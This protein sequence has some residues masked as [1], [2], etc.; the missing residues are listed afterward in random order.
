MNSIPEPFEAAAHEDKPLA[1]FVPMGRVGFVV[2]CT[3]L[4][5]HEERSVL[6][7]RIR[8]EHLNPLGIA[9]GGFL[10]TLADTAFGRALRLAAAT[11]LPPAT[12]NLSMDYLS[13]ANLGSWVEAHVQIH[14]VGRSLSHASLDLRD[15]ERLVARAKATFIGNSQ[16]LHGKNRNA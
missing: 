2:H 14:R 11:D 5:V 4:Y 3:G 1:G 8:P 7:A 9:H 6:A 12:I 10:A 15:G 13:P 16:S